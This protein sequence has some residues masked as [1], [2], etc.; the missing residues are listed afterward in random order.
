MSDAQDQERVEEEWTY[1]GVSP[2]GGQLWRDPYGETLNYAKLKGRIYGGI[3]LAQVARGPEPDRVSVLIDPPWSGRRAEDAAAIEVTAR[4][5]EVEAAAQRMHRNAS[6]TATLDVMIAPIVDLAA[7]MIK[8]TDRTALIE[9]ISA[10]VYGAQRPR[11]TR[12]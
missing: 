1:I 7:G 4:R 5:R 6:R 11:P 12:R 2:T 3:Y 9:Y 10:K 8:T